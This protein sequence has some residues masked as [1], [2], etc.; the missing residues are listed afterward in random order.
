MEGTHRLEWVGM[1]QLLDSAWVRDEIHAYAASSVLGLQQEGVLQ[2]LMEIFDTAAAATIPEIKAE[3]VQL[4]DVLATKFDFDVV[5]AILVA[6]RLR[7]GRAWTSAHVAEAFRAL[8]K[9]DL[10]KLQLRFHPDKL[11]KQI[12]SRAASDEEKVLST[13]CFQLFN[14]ISDADPKLREQVKQLELKITKYL[15]P[16]MKADAPGSDATAEIAS[17]LKEISTSSPKGKGRT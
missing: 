4:P 5:S 2:R 11:E 8:P 7:D 13:A 15:A 10:R 12:G 9:A 6:A 16:P 1:S 17:L 3:K 14:M